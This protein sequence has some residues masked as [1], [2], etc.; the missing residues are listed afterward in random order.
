MHHKQPPELARYRKRVLVVEDD[1]WIRSFMRD[2]LSDEGYEVIDAADGRTALRLV[3]QCSPHLMLLDLAMPE[4][5]GVDVLRALKTRRRTRSLPVVV[6]SAY[7]RV[8]SPRDEVSVASIL[9][10]PIDVDRLLQVVRQV[11]EPDELIDPA[12]IESLPEVPP[13]PFV[14]VPA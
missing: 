12:L 10:K 13:A 8:L 11:F 2:V 5:T 14:A 9:T 1:G 4:F 7:P 6:V 3:E